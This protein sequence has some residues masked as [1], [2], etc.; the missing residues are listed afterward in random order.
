MPTIVSELFSPLGSQTAN[1]DQE[2]DV[3]ANNPFNVVLVF[4][5]VSKNQTPLFTS[6]YITTK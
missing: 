4:E 3:P 2:Y 5:V 6:L 1:M